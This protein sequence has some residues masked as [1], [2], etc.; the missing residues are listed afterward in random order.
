MTHA[1]KKTC[2]FCC[3]A[4]SCLPWTA[5]LHQNLEFQGSKQKQG[6]NMMPS[7]IQLE[8]RWWQSIPVLVAGRERDCHPEFSQC[9]FQA[10]SKL[11]VKRGEKI[12]QKYLRK[13]SYGNSLFQI[14]ISHRQP[15]SLVSRHIFEFS[16]IGRRKLEVSE[17]S[18]ARGEED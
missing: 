9:L 11:T 12:I 18:G 17:S 7:R 5:S 15:Y 8:Y 3:S 1:F 16:T 4:L 6:N 10:A 2:Y 13:L 14:Y